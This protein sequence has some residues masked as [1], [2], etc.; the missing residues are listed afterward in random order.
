MRAYDDTKTQDILGDTC[1]LAG[2]V[3]APVNKAALRAARF[4]ERHGVRSMTVN[5]PA[6]LLAEFNE[7][8]AA[9]G[10]NKSEVIAKL[11]KTQL[12]RKR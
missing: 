11:I 3:P 2:P 1:D 4:R 7:W 5:L 12:L 8:A 9:K 10:K 6:E